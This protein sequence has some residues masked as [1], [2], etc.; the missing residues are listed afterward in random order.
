MAEVTNE[1]IYEILKSMQGRLSN[2][3]DKLVAIDGRLDSLT[4]QVRG[5]AMEMN[6][7][8]GDIANIYKILGRLDQRVTRI[9][10]RLDI[11]EEPAE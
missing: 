6:G 4:S 8:H 9:E 2:I 11:I 7:G 1:L 5:L 3:D 10:K